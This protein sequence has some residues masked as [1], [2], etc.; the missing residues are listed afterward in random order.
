MSIKYCLCLYV[1][2]CVLFFCDPV[3]CSPPVSSVP[4][5]FH[6]IY[7][8]Q[9]NSMRQM[10]SFSLFLK[11]KKPVQKVSL[12]MVTEWLRSQAGIQAQVRWHLMVSDR[13]YHSHVKVRSQAVS[14]K[15]SK[16]LTQCCDSFRAESGNLFLCVSAAQSQILCYFEDFSFW[17]ILCIQIHE[18]YI[19]PNV[20]ELFISQWHHC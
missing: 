12:P 9:Q 1:L 2:S 11:I 19:F 13:K 8:S 14:W 18:L 5:I 6:A 3:D 16:W 10:S 20:S 4:E 17:V 7:F 15:K